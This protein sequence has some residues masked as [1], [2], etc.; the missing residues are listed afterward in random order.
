[1]NENAINRQISKG[2]ALLSKNPKIDYK[3]SEYI[4]ITEDLKE[5]AENNREP[6]TF[7]FALADRMYALGIA[8]GYQR[9]KREYKQQRKQNNERN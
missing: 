5:L 1:M 9:A 6:D 7:D 8:R 2:K 3:V 4:L